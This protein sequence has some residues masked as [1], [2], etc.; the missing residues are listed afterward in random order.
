MAQDARDTCKHDICGFRNEWQQHISQYKTTHDIAD[1]LTKA[2]TR[3]ALERHKRTIG[4]RHVDAHSSQKELR[5]EGVEHSHPMIACTFSS[6]PA[7]QLP[8]DKLAKLQRIRCQ[9]LDVEQ[10]GTRTVS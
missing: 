2:A 3:E 8:C 6:D 1:I 4:L 5:L 10:K 7:Q 9:L